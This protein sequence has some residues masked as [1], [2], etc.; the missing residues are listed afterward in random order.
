MVG[1]PIDEFLMLGADPPP[2][3]RLFAAGEH[4]QQIIAGLDERAVTAGVGSLR[5]A[6]RRLAARKLPRQHFRFMGRQ[7]AHARQWP[8]TAMKAAR[9]AS[10]AVSA[11]RIRGPSEIGTE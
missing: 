8:A 11:R 7:A 3:A 6:R 1:H 9:A 5:H 10:A 4:R 2:L